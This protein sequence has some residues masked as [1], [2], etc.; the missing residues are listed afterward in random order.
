MD[1]STSKTHHRVRKKTCQP[2]KA[3]LRIF[4]LNYENNTSYEG[5]IGSLTRDT[6]AYAKSDG[7]H[8]KLGSY[9]I[10]FAG[11]FVYQVTGRFVPKAERAREQHES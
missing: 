11:V 9:G 10:G 2:K 6:V 1:Y 7:V 4:D 5:W 3:T 8:D